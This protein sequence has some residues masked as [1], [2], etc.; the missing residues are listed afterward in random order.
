MYEG[1]QSLA[2]IVLTQHLHSIIGK[3]SERYII[4][5]KKIVNERFFF[6]NRIRKKPAV[7]ADFNF[8]Q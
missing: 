7:E 8:I 4:I 3:I 6:P 2:A 5:L 1:N